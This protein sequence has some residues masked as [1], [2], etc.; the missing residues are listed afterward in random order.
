MRYLAL[1]HNENTSWAES[2]TDVSIGGRRPFGY[3]VI[4][5]MDSLGMLIDLAHT[6]RSTA[7]ASIRA[8]GAPA[9]MTHS[10]CRGLVDHPRNVDDETMRALADA[11]GVLMLTFV[12]PFISVERADWDAELRRKAVACG[13]DPR[14]LDVLRELEKEQ[15]LPPPKA[16]LFPAIEHLEYAREIVGVDSIGLAGDYDGM[17]D[18]PLEL[19]DVSCYPTIFAAL[20]EHGWSVTE[21]TKLAGQNTLRVLHEVESVA[22][23][24][25]R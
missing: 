9:V 10:S 16:T 20:L 4:S 1:T 6:S 22:K 11:G 12:P 13:K 8:S 17:S 3:E 23:S 21:C 24:L 19:E 2:A 7:L 25:T 5:E 18:V 14:N 15:E